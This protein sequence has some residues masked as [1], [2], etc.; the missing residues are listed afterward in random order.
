[1]VEVVKLFIIWHKNENK[2]KAKASEAEVI[3]LHP[4]VR[5]LPCSFIV[6]NH[7]KNHTFATI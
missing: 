4:V 2:A 6:S 7:T 3:T 5:A 1:M